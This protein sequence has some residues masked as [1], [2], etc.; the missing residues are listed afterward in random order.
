MSRKLLV[1][2][3]LPYANGSIHLGHLVEYIQTD[4]WVRFQKMMGN[5]CRYMCASDTHGTPIMINAQKQNMSPD[6]FIEKF[7]QEHQKDFKAFHIQFDYY[8]STHA[9]SNRVLSEA[10]FEAAKQA[11]AIETRTID[12]LYSEKDGMFLPDRFVKG[13]CPKCGALDQYGDSCEVCSATYSPMEL[14]NPRS[15]VS[16]DMPVVKSSLHYFFKLSVFTEVI[17]TWIQSGVVR[18]EVQKKLNEWFKEGLKDW[19]ISRDAPYFGFKIP[20]EELKYFY[21]WLDAPVGYVSA[22]QDWCNDEAKTQAM[23]RSGDWE[24]HHFIGKDILYFHTLFWPAML[25]AAQYQL[26]TKVNI[27]GFLTVNGEK[28]SKSRGTFVLASRFLEICDPEFLRYYYASKLSG[29]AEDL[30]LNLD[31]FVLKNNSDVI[32]KLI[33]IGSRL[34]SIVHK[35]LNGTLTTVDAEG[36]TVLALVRE[37]QADIAT[38]YETLQ[39]AKAMKTVMDCADHLNK[40]IDTQAPWSVAKDNPEKAAQICTAG[41]NGLRYLAI[42]LSPVLPR[43]TGDMA[44]Y[45]SCTLMWKDVETVLENHPIK[46][47]VHIANRLEFDTV[48]T[49][50]ELKS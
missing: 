22:T 8:G 40:Y 45:L 5:E 32:G 24:I 20:G 7:R 15:A 33:N 12:Q 13:T 18:P 25:S 19:D 2:S 10:F 27:H 1:T 23:W 31:D 39:Y 49:L 30:D 35:K 26:P 42:Y 46:P 17:E 47:Y 41:L 36:E 14:I 11:G 37:A 48:K 44:E 43:I 28:M 29:T 38:Y 3:A 9:E 6:L 16:G 21:V 4:I 50:L 34:G